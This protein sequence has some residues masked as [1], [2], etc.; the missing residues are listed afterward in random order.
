MTRPPHTHPPNLSSRKAP[1]T[2]AGAQAVERLKKADGNHQA[3][4]GLSGGVDSSLTAALLVE[5]GWD[6]EGMT[7]WLMSGKGSCCSDGLV[8]AAAICEQL[9]IP[10]HV[11]DSRNIFKEEI[12]DG[13][14]EGY[15][16]GITPIPCSRCNRSVKFSEMLRWAEIERNLSYI[17]TG[18]Y[19]RTIKIRESNQC[20]DLP[21]SS[22]RRNKLLRGIDKN[23][24]QSYFLYDL[25]QDVLERILFPLGALTKEDTRIEANR[26]GLRTAKKPESQDLCLAEHHGSMKNFLDAY[27]PARKGEI[28]LKDGTIL[29]EHDGIEHFTI[30]QR[31]GLGISWKEPLHVIH[32]D[33]A[34]NKVIV[35][36][37]AE[38][39]KSYC[40]VGSVNWVSICPPKNPIEIETQVRY[41]SKPVKAL[42]TPLTPT[43]EDLKDQRPHRCKLEFRKDQFS[44]APGQAAVFYHEEFVLGGGIIVKEHERN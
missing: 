5:A 10:H 30:G 25:T 1:T 3:A 43:E 33:A 15:K 37:R 8:D 28:V 35:A 6:I 13:L 32:I 7:L 29:G 38:A 2:N 4:V 27:L 22:N 34:M 39:G 42:L 19:A 24:D 20:I 11:I 41:R 26:L 23:K 40:I 18:H 16:E 12:I 21:E 31:K 9:G 17:A 14:I 36:T 44:I